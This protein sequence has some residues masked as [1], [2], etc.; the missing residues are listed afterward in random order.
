A[1]DVL[2]H[3]GCHVLVPRASLCCG[4]P[5]YDYGFLPTARRMLRQ[6]MDTLRDEIEQGIPIVGLEPSCAAVFRDE[7]LQLFPMDEDARRLNEQTFTLAE[8]LEKRVEG[9]HIPPLRRRALVHGH[10]HHKAIMRMEAEDA[11]F[12]KLGML[13]EIPDTG[14]CG[15]AG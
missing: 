11:I 9:F 5:L 6:V 2:E 3:A 13:Y 15:L 1:V 7:L 10:C 4:R 8:F 12:K 14:C